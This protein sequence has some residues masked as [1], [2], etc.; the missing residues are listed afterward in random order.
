MSHN[1]QCHQV[2]NYRALSRA[3]S[4]PLMGH[5][6]L[7]IY[8]LLMGS[9]KN[10]AT[11]F[12]KL[13]ILLKVTKKNCNDIVKAI[14]YMHF[15]QNVKLYSG[16][17]LNVWGDDKMKINWPHSQI[18]FGLLNFFMNFS[19]RKNYH[20]NHVHTSTRAYTYIHYLHYNFTIGL[21]AK[22]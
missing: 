13:C 20:N 5:H 22:K 19:K 16:W 3:R 4:P 7:K 2:Q 6:F 12:K 8:L 11:F 14:A 21:K 18:Q 9:F 10:L 17:T 1:F 15:G